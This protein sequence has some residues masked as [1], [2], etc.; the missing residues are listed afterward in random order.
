MASANLELVRS[1]HGVWERG[2]FSSVEWA[3][4]D[5]E[6]VQAD[7]PAPGSWIGL[8]GMA[9]VFRDFLSA[10]EEWRVEVD[11]YLEL[12]GG[13]V[14]VLQRF[15]ARGKTSG[16]EAGR[17][18]TEVASVFQ[19]RAGKVTRLVQYFDREQALTD[20]RLTPESESP[21]S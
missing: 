6:Y 20:L 18:R 14:V 19:I 17:I 21:R 8:A 5:I 9:E 11:E 2:D 7:G 16:F 3:H 12:D 15:S 10:W 4:P 13:R 1:I